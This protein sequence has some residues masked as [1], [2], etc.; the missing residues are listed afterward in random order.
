MR[1]APTLGRGCSLRALVA[2]SSIAILGASDRPSGALS[3]IRSLQRLG[4]G[5]AIYPVN[6]IKVLPEGRGCIVVDALIVTTPIVTTPIVTTPLA[7]G[8]KQ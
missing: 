1:E 5:G 4:F 6:P 7:Q 8:Q 2:P 3:L